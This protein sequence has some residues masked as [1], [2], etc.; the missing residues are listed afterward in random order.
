MPDTFLNPSRRRSHH[1]RLDT[2]TSWTRGGCVERPA[3]LRGFH[4]VAARKPKDV[5][6]FAKALKF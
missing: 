6:L 1:R 5:R 4:H 2:G 3:A